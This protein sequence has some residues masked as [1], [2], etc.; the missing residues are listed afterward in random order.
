LRNFLPGVY[1]ESKLLNGPNLQSKLVAFFRQIS[2]K[3]SNGYNF[4]FYGYFGLFL[5]D[6]T[7]PN[8]NFSTLIFKVLPI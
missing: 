3:D 4:A 6:L 7:N 8:L 1:P 2:Q 5:I